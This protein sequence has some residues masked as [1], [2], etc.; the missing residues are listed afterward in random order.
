[1]EVQMIYTQTHPHIKEKYEIHLEG[2]L[3]VGDGSR[4]R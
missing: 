4:K 1:M 2:L 3:R